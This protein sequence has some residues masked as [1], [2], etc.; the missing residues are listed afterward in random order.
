MSISELYESFNVLRNTPVY[1]FTEPKV[2]AD[3]NS[4]LSEIIGILIE[5]NAN[6]IFIPLSG[7]VAAMTM[8]DIL[9][10]RNITSSKPP[11]VGKIIPTLNP[12]STTA[13]A[14]RLMSLYRLRALPI[15]EKNEISGQISAKRI[16]QEIRGAMLVTHTTK[17]STSD[18]MTRNPIV[19]SKG[20]KISTAKQIMKRRRIDHIPVLQNNRLFGMVT[21]R[22]IVQM[23][24]PTERI[25]RKSLGI[26][27]SQN[28]LNLE[29][30][31]IAEKNVLTLNIDDTLRSVTDLIVT[32]NSTYCLIMAFDEVQGII[33]HRDIITLLG[34]KVQE[35]IPIFIIGLPDDPLDAELAKSKFA[36]IVKLLKK[37]YPDI[38]E[39]RCR[40]K[41][42]EIKGARKRYEVDANIISTHRM[43]TYVNVGWDLAKMFDQM[44]DSLKKRI[45]HKI[46]RRQK[47]TR[48]RSRPIA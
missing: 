28:R 19:I 31:G 1:D 45:S 39:A 25:G 11:T 20:D 10:I 40:L 7:K 46:T 30:G 6:D 12:Y 15:M 24:L 23:M 9:G 41:I 17:I 22:G 8:R 33:T 37:I 47:G 13:E 38:E 42:R 21:S 14:V 4:S 2:T 43:D 3:A 36:D 34:E 5:R 16:V 44:S 26:D 32:Q 27:G 48:F 35:E 18:V 29:I